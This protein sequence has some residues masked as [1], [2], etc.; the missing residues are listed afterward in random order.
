MRDEN[1]KRFKIY[2]L[3]SM[4]QKTAT[5]I[6]RGARRALT[7]LS[8][9]H[10]KVTRNGAAFLRLKYAGKTAENGG[11]EQGKK[12][13]KTGKKKA[14]RGGKSGSRSQSGSAGDGSA[15]PR[16][17]SGFSVGSSVATC[18][19]IRRSVATPLVYIYGRTSHSHRVFS[20][21]LKVISKSPFPS[22]CFQSFFWII[23]SC[24]NP[25]WRV[26]GCG[27]RSEPH[28]SM[29]STRHGAR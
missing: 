12:E 4:W 10:A 27:E 15:P 11:K 6:Y 21:Y 26:L 7:W 20:G 22:S 8:E 25:P 18:A 2:T 29:P 24:F 23:F 28:S 13:C 3:K 14:V 16:F 17:R 5:C 9:S 19:R 1:R